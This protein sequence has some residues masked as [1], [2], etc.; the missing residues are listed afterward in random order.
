MAL[1][2]LFIK[3]LI[4]LKIEICNPL[5]PPK[6]LIYSTG[7]TRTFALYNRT[8]MESETS[9]L[10]I[11]DEP[12]ETMVVDT[13][14]AAQRCKYVVY[15]LR[16]SNNCECTCGACGGCIDDGYFFNTVQAHLDTGEGCPCV[17]C[18]FYRYHANRYNYPIFRYEE[19]ER[20]RQ[21]HR[22]YELY[23]AIYNNLRENAQ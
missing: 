6:D 11:S 20:I 13:E 19:D 23:D 17:I 7:Y 22:E 2:F 18:D 9:T 10:F 15:F 3:N 5:N 1:I 8:K 16:R 21:M 4:K 12:Q 14:S